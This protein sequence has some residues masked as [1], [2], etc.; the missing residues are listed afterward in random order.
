MIDEKLQKQVHLMLLF[1]I[2]LDL[3][4]A[5]TALFFPEV[6]WKLLHGVAYDDPEGLQRRN[7]ALWAAFT[8]LQV[9]AL[10][11]WKRE[12]WWLPLV[13]GVRFTEMFTDW[14]ML[15]VAADKTWLGWI[16][17]GVSPPVTIFCGWFV[18]DRY[19]K[20]VAARAGGSAV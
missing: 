17:F 11:R 15:I 3:V 7:G 10:M 8:V 14:V 13:A 5:T 19:K 20:I 6:W 12:L 4:L 18:L 9:L 2:V 1:L 16:G